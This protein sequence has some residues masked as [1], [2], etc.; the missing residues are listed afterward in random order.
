LFRDWYRSFV[1][2]TQENIYETGTLVLELPF[3]NGYEGYLEAA[4]RVGSV[5]LPPSLWLFGSG[6]LGLVGIS[7][8]K[9]A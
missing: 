8:K 6:L 1:T 7:R 3:S 4:V 2:Y 9:V 5:P